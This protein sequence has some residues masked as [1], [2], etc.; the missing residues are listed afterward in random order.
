[1]AEMLRTPVAD[2][3]AWTVRDLE[4][5]T[6]WRHRLDARERDEV[7]DFSR[8]LVARGL[9][10]R[11]LERS[12]GKTPRFTEIVD[13]IEDELDEGRGL[14]LLS[15][16]PVEELTRPEIELLYAWFG[17][18]LGAPKSQSVTGEIIA[19]VTDRGSNY[20]TDP[21]ARGYL[22]NDE[23]RPHT[24]GCDISSLLCLRQAKRGGT[25][26]LASSMAI[27]NRVLAEHPEYL[28]ALYRGFHHDLRGYGKKGTGDETTEF[29]LPV[30]SFVAGKLSAGFNGKTI[31]TAPAK[32]G[33]PLTEIET[34]AVDFVEGLARDPALRADM[35]LAPGEIVAFSNCTTFHMRDEFEDFAEA[36]RKRLLLRLWINGN[37]PRP[38]PEIAAKMLRGGIAKRPGASLL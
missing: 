38:L 20:A 31:R 4:R 3:S 6:A 23:L 2:R 18:H 33:I 14:F 1:M 11:S 26:S 29:R 25:T 5:D 22:S 9:D 35:R 7:V 10:W 30:F 21:N 8:A 37:H 12:S 19:E 32:N 28:E 13:R 15:G 16:V 17:I 24:D 27:Y 36:E 34:A